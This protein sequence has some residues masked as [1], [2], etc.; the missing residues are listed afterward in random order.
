M[1][2]IPEAATKYLVPAQTLYSAVQTGRLAARKSGATWLVTVDAI[3]TWLHEWRPHQTTV[4]AHERMRQAD[5]DALLDKLD[6]YRNAPAGSGKTWRDAEDETLAGLREERDSADMLDEQNAN[7]ER[8]T[9]G[10]YVE[11]DNG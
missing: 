3:E 9:A 11:R 8:D 7:Y 6:A 10:G 2:T 1:L 4:N 5:E